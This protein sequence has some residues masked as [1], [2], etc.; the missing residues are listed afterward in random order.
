MQGLCVFMRG[1][2]VEYARN[3]DGICTEHVRN[4]NVWQRISMYIPVY[5]CISMYVH[6]YSDISMFRV[7]PCACIHVEYAWVMHG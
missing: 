3:T 4:I 7:Y 1:M 5:P 2:R 6:E